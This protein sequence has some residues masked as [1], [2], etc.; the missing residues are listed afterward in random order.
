[1]GFENII[2]GIA[3]NKYDAFQ[4]ALDEMFRY[5]YPDMEESCKTMLPLYNI[6]NNQSL[7]KVIDG[8]QI[9]VVINW[10]QE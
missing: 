3:N 10:N 9:F 2:I 7:D 8:N 6:K 5:K 4:D 1:V